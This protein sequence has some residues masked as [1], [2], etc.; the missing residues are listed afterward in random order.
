MMGISDWGNNK[1]KIM[2]KKGMLLRSFPV[3]MPKGIA[4]IPS[5]QLLAVSSG[6]H[7]IEMFD[8]SP[9]LPP[10]NNKDYTPSFPLPRLYS[11]GKGKRKSK[12][13]LFHFNN[14][15]NRI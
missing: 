2:D 10:N 7:V 6:K 14:P 3:V 1:V 12:E 9:L 13:D 15:R 8:I 11:I 5:L 4:I